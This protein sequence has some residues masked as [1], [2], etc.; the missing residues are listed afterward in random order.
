MTAVTLNEKSRVC[1]VIVARIGDTLLATPSL[2]ALRAASGHLSTL[3]HPQREVL[4]RHLDFIDELGTISK[5]TAWLRGHFPAPSFDVAFCWG[6]DPQLLRY[7]LRVARQSVA[8][9][10]PEFSAISAASLVRV[11]VPPDKSMHA[12]RE[13]LLLTEAAG[14]RCKDL[15][16]A[17]CVTGSE[18]D[19]ARTW[20][21]MHAGT[22]RPIVGVQPFSFHT[23]AHRDWP[24]E[25]FAELVRQLGVQ[26]P[27]AHF[28]ILG[29][30][31]AARHADAVENALPGRVSIAAGRLALRDSAALMQCLDLYIGVDTGPTHIAGA[32]QVPMIG[33]YHSQYP[34]RNLQPLDHPC[35]TVLEAEGDS[36]DSIPVSLVYEAAM[37]VLRGVQTSNGVKPS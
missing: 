14:V 34:G 5:R 36:M 31:A 2:R 35:C 1:A 16:L 12:V 33:L 28:V 6:R 21:A 10:Y 22:A 26:H 17:Y 15:R 27:S 30:E 29:D 20:L 19:A 32:L 4:L 25:R 37:R 11:T 23:K 8:F 7:C 24:I 3:V 9:D 18:R 13:R